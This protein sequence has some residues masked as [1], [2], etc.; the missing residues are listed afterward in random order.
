MDFL[1]A[2]PTI[3]GQTISAFAGP[4]GKAVTI[5]LTGGLAGI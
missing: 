1:A 4:A 3:A 5:G 2:L